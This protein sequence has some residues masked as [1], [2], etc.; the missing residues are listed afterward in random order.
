MTP[1]EQEAAAAEAA[2]LPFPIKLAVATLLPFLKD[3]LLTWGAEKLAD[4]LAGNA[5]QHLG[6]EERRQ[7]RDALQR[8]ADRLP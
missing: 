6:P 7:L 2:A 1:A 8:T 4:L 3:A 5:R